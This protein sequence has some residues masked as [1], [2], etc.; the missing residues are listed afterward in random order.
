MNLNILM[1]THNINKSQLSVATG[2]GINTISRYCNN[3]YEKLDKAH[4]DTLCR[5]FRCDLNDIIS[6][7]YER[8]DNDYYH[9]RTFLEET[10]KSLDYKISELV[11]ELRECEHTIKAEEEYDPTEVFRNKTLS[12]AR[13]QYI[14]HNRGVG[15]SFSLT[16]GVGKSNLTDTAI[17]ISKSYKDGVDCELDDSTE[18]QIK[19]TKQ[20]CESKKCKSKSQPKSYIEP[21]EERNDTIK[22]YINTMIKLQLEQTVNELKREL[23][24]SSQDVQDNEAM[25]KWKLMMEKFDE[26]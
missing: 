20:I 24:C 2:I 9:Y 5:Y 1:V 12:M 19:E 7:Q 23:V 15:K 21:S 22:E 25:N 11:T 6:Y 17:S 16:D 14:H 18:I 26:E 8:S 3:T 13:N 10:I 4:L